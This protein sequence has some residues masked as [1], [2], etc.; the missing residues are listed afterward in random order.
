[1]A[2][3]I[4][5][6]FGALD[7]RGHE[8]M[9]EKATGTLRFD[10]AN[11]KRIERWFVTVDRG[12]VAVSRRNR[13]ADCVVRLDRPTF[14]AILSRRANATASMLRGIV[15]IQGDLD[16]VVLFQRLFSRSRSPGDELPAHGAGRR[17]S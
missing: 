5:D 3:A 7:T 10:V 8:P 17:A 6:F 14:E 13:A 1:M 4:A 15:S 16:L 9:L 2:D 12:D 11:R